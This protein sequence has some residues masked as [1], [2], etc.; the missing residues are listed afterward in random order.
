[1]SDVRSGQEAG[2]PDLGEYCRRV[3]EHLGRVNQGHLIRIAGTAFELVRTWAIEGIPLSIVFRG[4]DEKAA[5][6]HAGRSRRPLR[7]EFCD[8]DVRALYDDW[9]RAVG[10]WSLDAPADPNSAGLSPALDE[11]RRP[12]LAKQLDRAITRLVTASARHDLPE[13]LLQALGPILDELVTLRDRA[14]Q[15]R[16]SARRPLMARAVEIDRAIG[17]AARQGG[18]E[19]E[20]SAHREAVRELAAFRAR[21]PVE[22]WNRSV[23]AGVDRLLRER[24]G[25]PSLDFVLS[26]S[27]GTA[28]SGEQ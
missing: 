13:R 23:D 28:S 19:S 10:A 24:Y 7:L 2:P 8:A 5:R 15:A 14:S 18:H 16:G 27:H 26:E 4:I 22:A 17:V 25:L 1:V 3:E 6:H 20:D 9:R 12:S 11:R 21:M